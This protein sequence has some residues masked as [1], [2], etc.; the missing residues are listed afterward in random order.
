MLLEIVT[1][2]MVFIFG[3]ISSKSCFIAA[4]VDKHLAMTEI[5]ERFAQVWAYMDKE[6]VQ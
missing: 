3:R 1:R 5:R 4:G 6:Q 2:D